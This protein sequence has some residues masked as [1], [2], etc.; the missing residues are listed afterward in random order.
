MKGDEIMWTLL[1]LMPVDPR[2]YGSCEFFSTEFLVGFAV[3][4][5]A[6]SVAAFII[7]KKSKKNDDTS[8]DTEN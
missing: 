8:L 3:A 5:V 2:Q 7:T 1:D 4:V 6:V